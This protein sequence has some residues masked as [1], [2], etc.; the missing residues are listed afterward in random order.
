MKKLLL[1]AFCFSA[2]TNRNDETE[3]RKTSSPIEIIENPIVGNPKRLG[4]IEIAENDFPGMLM[5]DQA[6]LACEGLGKDWRL[7]TPTELTSLY[8]NKDTIGRFSD[9]LY[10]NS[11]ESDTL[12]AGIHDF[13]NGKQSM[14]SK[15]YSCRVRAVRNL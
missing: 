15:I 3:T 2:C 8:R 6:R 1:I 4:I 7:P 11:L 10:W 14:F 9:G 12:T 13:S 5:W